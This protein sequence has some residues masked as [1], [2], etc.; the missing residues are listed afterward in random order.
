MTLELKTSRGVIEE[1]K[2]EIS[3]YKENGGIYI[4]LLSLR[5]EIPEPF[6]DVTINLGGSAIDYCGYLDTGNLPE[7]EVFIT[8]NGIGEYT[9]F[10]RRSGYNEYPFY[11][12]NAKRLQELCP[13]GLTEYEQSLEMDGKVE[14]KQ[15][16]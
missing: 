13:E 9:G 4:G 2:I 15:R 11:V 12:F 10:T 5:G 8:E 14:E 6:G 7:L 3:Y 16:V 1:A